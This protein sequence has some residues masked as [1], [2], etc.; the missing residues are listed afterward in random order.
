MA[1]LTSREIPFKCERCSGRGLVVAGR[2]TR[3]EH[4]KRCSTCRGRGYVD[5]WR[6]AA[7]FDRGRASGRKRRWA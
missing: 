2:H 5:P 6:H 3:L 1:D 7:A 4:L